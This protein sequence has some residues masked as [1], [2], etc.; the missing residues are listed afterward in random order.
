MIHCGFDP[1][2]LM[3]TKNWSSGSG[4]KFILEKDQSIHIPEEMEDLKV[5]LGWDTRLD[6]DSS[7]LMYSA[8]GA[9]IDKVFFGQK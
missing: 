1:V 9:L 3:E 8:D 7:L 2:I 6:L 5:G 4:Q